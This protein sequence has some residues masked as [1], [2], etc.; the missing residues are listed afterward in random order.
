MKLTGLHAGKI[1][2][3]IQSETDFNPKQRDMKRQFRQHV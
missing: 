2:I 3:H 1:P